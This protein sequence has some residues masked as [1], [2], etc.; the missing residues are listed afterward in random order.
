[1]RP[2]TVVMWMQ[3][4]AGFAYTSFSQLADSCDVLE[5][6]R[7]CHPDRSEAQWRAC[8]ERSRTGTCCFSVHP[9]QRL[10][11]K[12]TV[13][14]LVIP[15]EAE[16]SAVLP[17]SSKSLGA[18]CPIQARFWLEWDTTAFNPPSFCHPACPGVPWKRSRGICSSAN[19]QQIAGIPRASMDA[20]WSS[21]PQLAAASRNQLVLLRQEFLHDRSYAI[22]L[23]RRE[24]RNEG[25]NRSGVSDAGN[26]QC[27]M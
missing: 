22:L 6:Q 8:P 18:G 15:S 20:S 1:M 14:P 7:N 11:I 21:L 23:L 10:L 12:V 4:S 16:G 13:L 2:P 17:T 5:L 25:R 9:I 26:L 19:Q 3:S 24:L 27:M